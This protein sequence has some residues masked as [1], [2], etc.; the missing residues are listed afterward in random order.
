MD[1]SHVRLNLDQGMQKKICHHSSEEH[2]KISKIAKFCWQMIKMRKILSREVC[3]FS[4]HLYYARKNYH[5]ANFVT[6]MVTYSVRNINIYKIRKLCEVIS[7]FYNICEQN[8]A[9]L[10]ILRSSLELW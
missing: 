8:F 6:K 9:I 3:E 7:I 5:R 4:I 1:N 10:L 2:Q